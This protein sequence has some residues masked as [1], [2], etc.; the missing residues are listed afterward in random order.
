[1]QVS[2]SS[3]GSSC[4]FYPC[5]FN[6]VLG[7]LVPEIILALLEAFHLPPEKRCPI[8]PPKPQERQKGKSHKSLFYEIKYQHQHHPDV[9]ERKGMGSVH[10]FTGQMYVQPCGSL[11]ERV[12]L[13]ESPRAPQQAGR[14]RDWRVPCSSGSSQRALLCNAGG[15]ESRAP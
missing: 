8:S 1:M 14:G 2:L 9:N 11:E 7:F 13:G 12:R 4:F 15:T 6:E 10:L 3:V 5:S